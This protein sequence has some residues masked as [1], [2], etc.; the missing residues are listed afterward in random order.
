MILDSTGS[1]VEKLRNNFD[2]IWNPDK[3]KRAYYHSKKHPIKV[4]QE[5][6]NEFVATPAA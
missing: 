3:V 6:R 5:K 4:Y 2:W 1:N